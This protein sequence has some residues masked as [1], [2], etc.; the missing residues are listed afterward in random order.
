[1]PST[2]KK[3]RPVLGGKNFAPRS[4][5]ETR[6]VINAMDYKQ[7]QNPL[8]CTIDAGN[9]KELAESCCI[10]DLSVMLNEECTKEN[11][12][13]KIREVGSRCMPDDVFVYYYS[14]HGTNIK[15]MSGDEADG[16]D[17]AF[18]FVTPDG[19]INFESC[20]IDDDFAKIVTSAIPSECFTLIIT[21]CCHSGTISDFENPGWQGHTAISIAGCL[22]SQTSGDMGRG[23]IC[24]HS[25]LMA[26]DKLLRSGDVE[27]SVGKLFNA[28][29]SED[30]SIFN[31]AQDIT[32]QYTE[33]CAPDTIKF[34]LIPVNPYKAPLSKAATAAA[35]SGEVEESAAG[36]TDLQALDPE[37][38]QQMGLSPGTVSNI[39]GSGIAAVPDDYHKKHERDDSCFS[40][41]GTM[42]GKVCG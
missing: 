33:G 42:M 32:V 21:D 30:N 23:G 10:S 15:D 22:D 27:F 1:M 35:G 28:T 5:G 2:R 36:G 16:N 18:C 9:M 39:T 8:T 37:T 29:L 31:S 19:Q 38:L 7:T 6:M 34:P 4:A 40:F 24:T 41:F 13:A 26:I 20:M 17:E 25:M 12:E 14:G 3:N 11:V